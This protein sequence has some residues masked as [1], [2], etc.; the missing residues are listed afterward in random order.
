[1]RM[2]R[3]E[4]ER[5]Y[6]ELWNEYNKIILVEPFVPSKFAKSCDVPY[7][8]TPELII[9]I[10]EK[11]EEVKKALNGREEGDGVGISNDSRDENY[12]D[13]SV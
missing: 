6:E 1:M 3:C 2:I 5:D 8:M 7:T 4:T 11:D 10:G 13:K 12:Y 9:V